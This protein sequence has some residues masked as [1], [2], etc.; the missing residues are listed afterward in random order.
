MVSAFESAAG[1][2]A[3]AEIGGCN[4][5]SCSGSW[6]CSAGW[7]ATFAETTSRSA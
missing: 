3:R 4:G 5:S 1:R 6:C 2:R 7:N